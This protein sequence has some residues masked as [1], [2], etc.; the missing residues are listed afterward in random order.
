[1]QITI[2]GIPVNSIGSKIKHG[3]KITVFYLDGKYYGLTAAQ[4]AKR[5]D[6]VTKD[7]KNSEE[8]KK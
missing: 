4:L 7:M 8:V 1:M 6:F 2:N 3:K 5:T